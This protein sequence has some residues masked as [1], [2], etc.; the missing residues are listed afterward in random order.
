MIRHFSDMTVGNLEATSEILYA[1]YAS[2]C[3]I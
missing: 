1:A 2:A 3:M